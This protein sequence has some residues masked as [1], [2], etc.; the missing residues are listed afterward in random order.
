M[1][2]ERRSRGRGRV[3]HLLVAALAVG[4]LLALLVIARRRTGESTNLVLIVVDTLR[5]DRTSLHGCE[6][7]TTPAI[8][9]WAEGG[10][11]FEHTTSCSS[12]TLPAMAGLFTGRYRV[13]GGNPLAPDRTVLAEALRARGYRTAAIVANPILQQGYGFERGFD[14]FDVAPKLDGDSPVRWSARRVVE[15]ALEWLGERPGEPFFL[16]LH[17]MDPHAPYAPEGGA[18]FPAHGSRERWER[19]RANL[20]AERAGELGEGAYRRVEQLRALYDSEVLQVDR[21][22]A[23]L[24]ERLERDDL[25]ERTLVVLTA[26]HGEGLWDRAGLGWV[27]AAT[28]RKGPVEGL[29]RGHGAQL[30]GE[31]VRVP[32]VFRGPGVPRGRRRPELV[33]LIDVV[34]SVLALLDVAP[35]A[36]VQGSAL[37]GPD[38]SLSRRELYAYCSRGTSVTLDGRW[39]LHLPRRARIERKGARPRLYD[40]ERDPREERPLDDPA[41]VEDLA[42]RIER[43][44]AR[45][46][47]ESSPADAEADARL[48]ALLDATGYAGILDEAEPEE[49]GEAGESADD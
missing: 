16:Y 14:S 26:D 34:P 39:R 18:A 10:T 30:F 12:W 37:F 33:S 36:E 9:R 22:L 42:R 40:L 20:P 48:R 46:R 7:A 44:T 11:V 45:S 31:Q 15:R 17:L 35:L 25:A 19:L 32:L 13:G 24:F 21:E 5:A 41:R 49:A 29:Y 47:A 1:A 23:R 2:S 8:E 27:N 38:E 4:A 3:G 43:W 6:H 28:L